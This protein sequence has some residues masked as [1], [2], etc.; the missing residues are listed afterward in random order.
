MREDDRM[1]ERRDSIRDED[2]TVEREIIKEKI[3]G[4]RKIN[5]KK[6]NSEKKY[7]LFH[8]F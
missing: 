4:K 1:R 3:N 7:H 5:I 2:K 8:L 6:E